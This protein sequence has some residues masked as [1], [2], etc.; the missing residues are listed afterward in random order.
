MLIFH[1]YL[2]SWLA[3]CKCMCYEVSGNLN[4]LLTLYSPVTDTYLPVVLSA[5]QVI[6]LQAGLL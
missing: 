5:L 2:E 6:L 4:E 3:L 1:N